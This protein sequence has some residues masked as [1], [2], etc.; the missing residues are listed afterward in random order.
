MPLIPFPTVGAA[1]LLPLPSPYRP[2]FPLHCPNRILSYLHY[3]RGVHFTPMT[4]PPVPSLSTCV[5]TS[6][7]CYLLVLLPTRAITYSRYPATLYPACDLR[8][9]TIYHVASLYSGT[10]IPT[11]ALYPPSCA[12]HPL[13][14]SLP[15]PPIP[16]AS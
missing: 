13:T 3:L 7:H 10:P 11:T 12:Y 14:H 1:T 15:R 9:P 5:V 4:H 2:F 16:A 6:S 8:Y